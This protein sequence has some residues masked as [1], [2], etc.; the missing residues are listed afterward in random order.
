MAKQYLYRHYDKDGKLLYVGVSNNFEF[1][2]QS[3][4]Y[5]SVW[6]EQIVRFTVDIY[7]DRKS[8]LKAEDLAIKNEEPLYNRP[9]G[10]KLPRPMGTDKV[11]I[12]RLP[13]D[14]K[15]FFTE[16]AKKERR[17]L[18]SEIILMLDKAYQKDLNN[19][20]KEIA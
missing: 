7:E 15:T 9:P 12:L 4:R 20:Q 1:R 13:R 8:V 10:K 3:H 18:N 2:T 11:F 16:H 19:K 6:Y 17:S 5:T 14:L